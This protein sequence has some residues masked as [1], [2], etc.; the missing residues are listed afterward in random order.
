MTGTNEGVRPT[1]HGE[2]IPWPFVPSLHV[3]ACGLVRACPICAAPV[4]WGVRDGRV[5]VVGIA[6]IEDVAP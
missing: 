2:P 6:D 3:A 1:C 5:A 4:R